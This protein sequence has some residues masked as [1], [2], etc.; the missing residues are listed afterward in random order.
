MRNNDNFMCWSVEG[1]SGFM[2]RRRFLWDHFWKHQLFRAARALASKPT[3]VWISITAKSNS[4]KYTHLILAGACIWYIS[5][6]QHL[7]W[8]AKSCRL[9]D[10][11]HKNDF[12]RSWEDALGR[13][14]LH[15]I[16]F[17]R[18]LEPRMPHVCSPAHSNRR[19]RGEWCGCHVN[20]LAVCGALGRAASDIN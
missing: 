18:G 4:H 17:D 3:R 15:W 6:F 13:Y 2:E 9:C 16:I 8:E 11:Q 7:V 19:E 1:L 20:Q 10:A 12:W 14:D 5:T